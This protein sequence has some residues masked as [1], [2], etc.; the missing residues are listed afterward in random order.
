MMKLTKI[1]SGFTREE[2]DSEFFVCKVENG[3]NNNS[4]GDFLWFSNDGTECSVS[5]Y[6]FDRME[7]GELADIFD[8]DSIK[9][10]TKKFLK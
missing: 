10:L 8:N 1:T 2:P 3:D 5:E 6:I 4:V 7:M 9:R